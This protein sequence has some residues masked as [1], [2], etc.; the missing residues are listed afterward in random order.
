VIIESWKLFLIKSLK[1][2][3]ESPK[4]YYNKET[5]LTLI[6]LS[7]PEFIGGKAVFKI[8]SSMITSV[9]RSH[10]EKGP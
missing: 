8:S 10:L 7:F 6:K 4:K 3:I 5:C 2:H 1:I 9:L